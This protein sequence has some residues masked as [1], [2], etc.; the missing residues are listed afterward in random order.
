MGGG[1]AGYENSGEVFLRGSISSVRR[2]GYP[3]LQK[4]DSP[5]FLPSSYLRRHSEFSR[6]REQFNDWILCGVFGNRIRHSGET[7]RPLGRRVAEQLH[8]GLFTNG[9]IS[10]VHTNSV[11]SSYLK[12]YAFDIFR[13][14]A[15]ITGKDRNG[16]TGK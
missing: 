6:Y 13:A 2:R 1:L 12:W 9:D 3:A 15:Q 8:S 5:P 11:H 4:L 14:S 10:R 16:F 7:I